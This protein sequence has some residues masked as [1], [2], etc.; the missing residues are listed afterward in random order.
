MPDADSLLGAVMDFSADLYGTAAGATLD[1][2][3][4]TICQRCAA[5][6]ARFRTEQLVGV[7]GHSEIHEYL[8]RHLA[9]VGLPPVILHQVATG[10]RLYLGLATISEALDVSPEAYSGTL[11]MVSIP[12]AEAV[13]DCFGQH[14][15]ECYAIATTLRVINIEMHGPGAEDRFSIARMEP[16]LDLL[17]VAFSEAHVDALAALS[18]LVEDP[19]IEGWRMKLLPYVV[20]SD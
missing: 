14:A 16:V 17:R 4:T 12:A 18:V 2:K 6:A 11:R 8:E 20:H 15:I 5:T 9:L 1:G 13:I 19:K 10:L 7:D 3:L